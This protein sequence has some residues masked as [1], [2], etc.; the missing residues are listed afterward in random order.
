LGVF[1][2]LQTQAFALSKKI[3]FALAHYI[4]AG[5]YENLNDLDTALQQYKA[6]LRFDKESE[7]IRLRLATAY[8]KTEDFERAI[9]ELNLA[10][11][12]NPHSP[13]PHA[14]LTLI[15]LAQQKRQLADSE[16]EMTLKKLKEQDPTNIYIYKELARFYWRHKDIQSAVKMYKI[17]LELSPQDY[18]THFLLGTLY[19][20]LH[21]REEAIREFSKTLQINPDHHQTLNSLGYL[22][23]EGGHNLDKAEALIKKALEF[24][25]S[26]GAYIDSLG[27]VYFKKGK[28]KE[29]IKLLEQAVKLLSDPVIY[30]HLA[31]AY[32][33]IGN[34][35]KALEYWRRSLELDPAQEK[36]R[37][38]YELQSKGN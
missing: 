12:Y 13:Q 37:K 2:L 10:A 28:Y 25:P 15:Y 32:L 9:E 22:Y 23:A 36:V 11:R 1:L 16:Y 19:E 24:Q 38:K 14:I 6:A 4:M 17:V 27:W 8:V 20:D 21:K 18:E 34:K 5:V 33:K 35:N 3:S 29:A 7:I 31:D 30:D 26:N